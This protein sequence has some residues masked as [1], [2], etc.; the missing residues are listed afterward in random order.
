M[1]GKAIAT[2]GIAEGTVDK[3]QKHTISCWLLADWLTLVLGMNLVCAKKVL[4]PLSYIPSS[5]FN[6]KTGN[7]PISRGEVIPSEK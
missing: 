6:T 4:L 1:E 7:L 3:M 5:Y 2:S